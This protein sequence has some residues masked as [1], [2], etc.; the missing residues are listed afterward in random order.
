MIRLHK[1][2]IGEAPEVIMAQAAVPWIMGATAAVGA[3]SAYSGQK[4][5]KEAATAA[6]ADRALQEK[7]QA[8]Q[9]ALI[10]A[11]NQEI[12]AKKAEAQ[13]VADERSS[14]MSQNQL[15]SGEETGVNP[16]TALLSGAK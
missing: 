6:D 16:A 12:E 11:Q 14:R 13:A 15:L 1:Q 10:E 9:Q 4:N 2:L 7:E 5:A 3:Y 8:K